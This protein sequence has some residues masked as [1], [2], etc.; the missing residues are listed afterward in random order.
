MTAILYEHPLN[1]RIRNYLK[2][3]QLFVQAS[4]CLQHNI[5]TSHSVFFNMGYISKA[6]RFNNVINSRFGDE[7][8]VFNNYDNEIIKAIELGYSYKSSIF[9]ANVNTYYTVWENKPLSRGCYF[10][11]GCPFSDLSFFLNFGRTL[12]PECAY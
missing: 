6:Q 4:E 11:K 2:L 5:A 7:L 8:L 12:I 10:E 9:S 1:E 3:E